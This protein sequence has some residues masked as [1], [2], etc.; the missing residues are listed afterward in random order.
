MYKI[1]ILYYTENIFGIYPMQ[2]KCIG[3]ILLQLW[4]SV[5][6]NIGFY[7]MPQPMTLFSVKHNLGMVGDSGELGGSGPAPFFFI[8]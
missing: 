2:T 1:H 3:E 8:P 5:C 6:C 4:S 7:Y